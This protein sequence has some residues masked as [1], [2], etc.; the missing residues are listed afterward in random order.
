MNTSMPDIVYIMGPARSG[1]TVLEILL[2]NNP[3]IFGVGELTHIFRDGFI[4]DVL[5]SCGKPTS[6]CSTWSAVLQRCNWRQDDL[7]SFAELFRHVDWHTKF[8]M[9]AMDFV[10]A[11]TLQRYQSVNKKLFQSV[12]SISG[13]SVMVDSSKYAG[14]ALALSKSFPG[15]LWVICMTRSPA[16]LVASFQ[17]ND[18][19]EQK[20]KSL[21]ATMTYYFYVMSCLK[22]VRWRLGPRVLLLRFESLLSDPQRALVRI[23]KWCGINLSS[24]RQ[25]LKENAWF[26]VGHIVTGNRLRKQG[27]IRLSP[28][29]ADANIN[30][31]SSH[32]SARIM[33]AYRLLLR[34]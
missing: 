13:A 30:G 17:R 19:D 4:R 1:T 31:W 16:G 21:P 6:Q 12:E 23:E 7:S 28:H 32:F 20:A 18:T 33:D 25:K 9:L 24:A 22:I 2:A 26:D 29:V 15:K 11:K 10:P 27:R 34:L 8:P 5:C 14:R 3:N